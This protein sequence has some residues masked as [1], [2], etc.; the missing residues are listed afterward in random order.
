MGSQSEPTR[1]YDVKCSC[2]KCFDHFQ[3]YNDHS[4]AKHHK[5]YILIDRETGEEVERKNC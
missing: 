3:A 5:G 1:S 4:S 2:G